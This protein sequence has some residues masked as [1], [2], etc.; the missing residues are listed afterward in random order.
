MN[1]MTRLT[2]YLQQA[3]IHICRRINNVHSTT[4]LGP[5]YVAFFIHIMDLNLSYKNSPSTRYQGE[6]T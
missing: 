5:N 6:I 2:S 3:S 4:P 1:K